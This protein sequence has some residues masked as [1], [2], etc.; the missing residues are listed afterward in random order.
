MFSARPGKFKGTM[1]DNT[2]FNEMIH[3]NLFC[4]YKKIILHFVGEAMR[5]RAALWVP[6]VIANT[7]YDYY[8]LTYVLPGPP[9]PPLPDFKAHDAGMKF[10]VGLFQINTDPFSI[11]TKPVSI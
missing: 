4:R 6:N 1:R 7:L 9:P 10:F 3:V 2:R 11:C 8:G 5:Y